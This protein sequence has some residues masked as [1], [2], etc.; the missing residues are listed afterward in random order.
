MVQDI[1]YLGKFYVY[2]QRECPF[3]FFGWSECSMS[4]KTVDS[5]VEVQHNLAGCLSLSLLFQQGPGESHHDLIFSAL[6]CSCI[7]FTY[8]IEKLCYGFIR[9]TIIWASWSVEPLLMKLLSKSLLIIFV[10]DKI[11]NILLTS[12]STYVSSLCFCFN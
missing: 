3:C 6:L 11:A 8:R 10:W 4:V 1:I 2:T 12:V 9:F 5:V 7:C